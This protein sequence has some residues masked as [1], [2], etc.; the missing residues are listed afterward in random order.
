LEIPATGLT[1][2][3]AEK[4]KCVIAVPSPGGEGQDEGERHL[5]KQTIE[6]FLTAKY[7]KYAKGEFVRVFRVVRG[8][9]IRSGLGHC[10]AL[11]GRQS[12]PALARE[13]SKP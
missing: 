4:S 5:P 6:T 12:F 13:S 3:S 11:E 7:A 10:V 2:R 8:R 9:K 1:G